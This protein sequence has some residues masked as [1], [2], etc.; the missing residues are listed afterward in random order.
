MPEKKFGALGILVAFVITLVP[1][2]IGFSMTGRSVAIPAI[3]ETLNVVLGWV[4]VVAGLVGVYAFLTK[5][6]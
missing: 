6:R 4:L 1:I 5:K 3:G 2:I